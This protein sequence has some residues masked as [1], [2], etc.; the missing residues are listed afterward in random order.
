MRL[1]S[2]IRQ[3]RGLSEWKMVALSEIDKESEGYKWL[4]GVRKECWRSG[5]TFE[6][7]TRV[8]MGLD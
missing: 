2:I 4:K 3:N 1:I 5:M 8:E 6:S 7:L